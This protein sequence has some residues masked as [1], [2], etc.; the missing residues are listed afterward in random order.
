[1]GSIKRELF[2]FSS[3]DYFSL[4]EH[5]EDMARRGWMLEKISFLTAKYRRIEPRDLVF[6]VDVYPE[7]KYFQTMDKKDLK[8]YINLCEEAGWKYVT[9][10]NNLQIF[11]SNK[12]DNLIPVQTDEEIKEKVVEKSIFMD[13]LSIILSISIL[14]SS[15]K[16]LL[17]YNYKNLFN[18]MDLLFPVFAPLMIIGAIFYIAGNLLWLIRAKRYI[19]ENKPLPRTNYT[20]AKIKGVMVLGTSILALVA[21]I[22]SIIMDSIVQSKPIFIF[23]APIILMPAITY[24][25]HKK[26]K[27][28]NIGKFKKIIFVTVAVF[29][30][31]ILTLVAAINLTSTDFNRSLKEGYIGFT[32]EDFNLGD[33]PYVKSFTNEGSVLVPQK[34]VYWEYTRGRDSDINT[35]YIKSINE[36]IANYIFYEMIKEQEIKY[37][38]LI[39]SAINEYTYFDEAYYINKP[40]QNN[41]N[42]IIILLKDNEILLIYGNV[43]FSHKKN[44][45][46][47]TNKLRGFTN[48]G[49]PL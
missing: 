10:S 27:A 3:I 38:R 35:I 49:E 41:K 2:L 7:L 29:A 4:K 6:S 47:I 39:D 48:T 26:I 19:K 21:L 44:I 16:K 17:P 36:K 46:I 42:N 30:T 20:L 45:E 11:Y 18:N 9:S 33:S 28:M 5:F 8:S 40:G 13:L 37:H 43:D 31:Y 1:M 12:E 14:S 22:V 15:L 34:S 32:L 23:L 25:Y 24:I